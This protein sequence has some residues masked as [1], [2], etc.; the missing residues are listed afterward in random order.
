MP[1]GKFTD[2]HGFR[3]GKLVAVSVM[4]ERDKFGY[5]LWLCKCD[6]GGEKIVPSRYLYDKKVKFCDSCSPSKVCPPLPVGA[7]Y[8]KWTVVENI[9]V[10][11]VV[12]C[13]CG[14]RYTRRRAHFL[15][16]LSKSCRSCSRSGSKMITVNGVSKNQLEWAKSLGITRQAVN[17]RIRF[18]WDLE[19][20]VTV[21]KSYVCSKCKKPGHNVRTC[22]KR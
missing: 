22:G 20:A 12:E 3:S 5:L 17:Q 7:K 1:N 4:N 19:M 13:E 6:C 16:Q 21:K 9:G 2:Y 10:N 15:F 14:K 11:C 18:G 8:N